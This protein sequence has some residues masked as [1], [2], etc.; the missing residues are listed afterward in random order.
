MKCWG[1][2]EIWCTDVL[3]FIVPK[4]LF[5]RS[6]HP[7]SSAH[8]LRNPFLSV[9]KPCGGL[10]GGRH[11]NRFSIDW[12]KLQFTPISMFSYKRM[13]TITYLCEENSLNK[14]M[15]GIYDYHLGNGK[16]VQQGYGNGT[17]PEPFCL[18]LAQL[19]FDLC[20]LKSRDETQIIQ[21]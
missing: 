19:T 14:R 9:S 12:F 3:K 6:V 5:L 13:Q 15:V 2:F 20:T 11:P 8:T 1:R 17:F 4:P 18:I 16:T 7:N 21:K 10:L